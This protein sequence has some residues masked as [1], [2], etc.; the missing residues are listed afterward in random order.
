MIM[1]FHKQRIHR[2]IFNIGVCSLESW[3]WMEECCHMARPPT[4][5]P[6]AELRWYWPCTEL[7]RDWSTTH[8]SVGLALTGL[9]T[10]ITFRSCHAV[11]I[12]VRS[13]PGQT[14]WGEAFVTGINS[15][16]LLVGNPTFSQKLFMCSLINEWWWWWNKVPSFLNAL[17]RHNV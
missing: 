11:I 4:A 2:N 7:G 3:V 6:S 1:T 13:Q 9:M 17:Q 12:Q 14:A 10:G 5:Q 15:D 8:Y 16:N